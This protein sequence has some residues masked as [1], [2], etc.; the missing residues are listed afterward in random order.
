MKS[1]EYEPAACAA[2]INCWREIPVT[3]HSQFAAALLAEMRVMALVT[4]STND[5]EL[6]RLMPDVLHPAAED[7]EAVDGSMVSWPPTLSASVP[8]VAPFPS[9]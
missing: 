1:A 2:G 6:P 9:L 8:S 5:A 3:C 7:R 4:P